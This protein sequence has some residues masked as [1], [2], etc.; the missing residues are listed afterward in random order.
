MAWLEVGPPAGQSPEAG[1]ADG[2]NRARNSARRWNA[3]LT[4]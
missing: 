3:S 4:H 2:D 1:G